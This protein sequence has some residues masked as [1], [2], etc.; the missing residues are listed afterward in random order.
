[1]SWTGEFVGVMVKER[2][3]GADFELAFALA[4]RRYSID[5]RS[6][7]GFPGSLLDPDPE[8]WWKGVCRDAWYSAPALTGGPSRLYL[9]P[10]LVAG[11][12]EGV[13]HSSSA[14]RAHRAA[15]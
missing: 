6:L 13:D 2:E 15:A 9:L 11:M 5:P 7:G 8:A 10:G 4:R 14:R 3:G 12:R 1:M